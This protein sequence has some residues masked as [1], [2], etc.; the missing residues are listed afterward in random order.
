[1][2]MDY[3]QPWYDEAGGL[4][5]VYH[6]LR[7]VY[8]A[9]GAPRLGDHRLVVP[10]DLQALAFTIQAGGSGAVAGQPDRRGPVDVAGIDGLDPVRRGSANLD[11]ESFDA[12]AADAEGLKR[13]S[14]R[15]S[16]PTDAG[17][18]RNVARLQTSSDL[19]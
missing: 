12:C 7:G 13:M 3:G 15:A 17:A 1:M 19:T 2:A 8:A 18:L 11:E 9:S 16:G 5:P 14:S 4:Y 6:V 10:R